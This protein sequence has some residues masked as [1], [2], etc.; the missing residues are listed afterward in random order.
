MKLN[1][2]PGNKI[3]KDLE[4]NKSSFESSRLNKEADEDKHTEKL[5]LNRLNAVLTFMGLTDTTKRTQLHTLW[6]LSKGGLNLPSII[7]FDEIK[8]RYTEVRLN[9]EKE[10]RKLF[11]KTEKEKEVLRML[12]TYS[13]MRIDT[14]VFLSRTSIDLYIHALGIIIEVDGDFHD[15]EGKMIRDNH[16]IKI[17]Q[18]LGI[19]FLS[20]RNEDIKSIT[21]QNLIKDICLNTQPLNSIKRREVYLSFMIYTLLDCEKNELLDLLGIKSDRLT[22]LSI[23]G[24]DKILS[25]NPVSEKELR[26]LVRPLIRY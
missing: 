3:Y 2:K 24:P 13:R 26:T 16:K 20:I 4:E 21:V 14:A 15:K 25:S 12:K 5:M 6:F 17:T 1:Y 11:T 23:H 18:Q 7:S 10:H 22:K 19:K 9:A 8:K